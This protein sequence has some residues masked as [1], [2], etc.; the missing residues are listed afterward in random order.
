MSHIEN[1]NVFA[2]FSGDF[3]LIAV[4]E[5]FSDS[6]SGMELV[7]HQAEEKKLL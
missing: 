1:T 2:R 3:P 7:E 4:E 5:M 6:L